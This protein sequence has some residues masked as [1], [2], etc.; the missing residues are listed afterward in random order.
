M[1]NAGL[2]LDRYGLPYIPGSAVKGCAR[3]MAIQQLL[4]IEAADEATQLLASIAFVFGWGEQ[5]WDAVNRNKNGDLVS[6]FA[7][8]IGEE[9]WG[10]VSAD[11]QTIVCEKLGAL[12]FPPNFAGSVSFMPSGTID[13]DGAHLELK[14]PSVGT[15]ELDVLTSHHQKYYG[16]SKSVA[17]DDEDPV[18]VYFPAVAAGH[19]FQFNLLPLRRCESILLRKAEGWLRESLAVLGIGAK[20]NA[21]YGWFDTSD[22]LQKVITVALEATAKVEQAAIERR[23]KQQADAEAEAIRIAEKRERESALASLS[24]DQQEDF[25]LDQ[26]DIGK[27]TQWVEKFQSHSEPEKEAI[28]RL[29]QN[30]KPEFWKELRSKAEQGIAKE[31]KRFGPPVQAMFKMAKERKEKMPK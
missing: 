23:R 20:T 18:P 27:L 28:Y 7:Y 8:A 22:E 26:M 11:V 25:K 16:G 29:L 1:E 17:T 4:E 6:D 19:V 10:S 13:V 3:R 2:Y 31:K 21:G 14:P 15:L 24:P 9:N 5:D 30:R 12:S